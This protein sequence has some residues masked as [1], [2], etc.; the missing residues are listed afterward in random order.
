MKKIIIISFFQTMYKKVSNY[1][2]IF[3][4]RVVVA[5]AL[6]YVFRHCSGVRLRPLVQNILFLIRHPVACFNNGFPRKTEFKKMYLRIKET[7]NSLY[8]D[9]FKE[10][11]AHRKTPLAD[12]VYVKIECPALGSYFPRIIGIAWLCKKLGI[13]VKFIFP[14]TYIISSTNFFENTI[15]SYAKT[16]SPENFTWLKKSLVNLDYRNHGTRPS[17]WEEFTKRRISSEFGYKIISTLSIKQEIQQQADQWY[18]ANIKDKCVGVH[19][20]QT[21]VIHENR[22]IKIEDYINYLKQ[23]LDHHCMILTCS[24]SKQFIDA[25]HKAFAG[26]VVSRD[27]VRSEDFQSLHRHEAYA[28]DQQRKD[29]LIDILTLAKTET[30][31]TVGS[32]FIDTI[33]FFNPS[34]KIISIDERGKFYPRHSSNYPPIPQKH[35]A[36]KAQKENVWKTPL[37]DKDKPNHIEFKRK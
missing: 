22:I 12:Y 29:A 3:K 26:R 19:Y 2:H 25:I 10:Y 18:R 36:R 31:Y 5:Y 16:C 13:N 35:L 21:D 6:F 7:Y 33:K 23:V 37:L 27:I 28:G 8:R 20:R 34:I 15:L 9:F 24:D 30:I 4:A 11:I 17:L 14:D 32:F 1:W